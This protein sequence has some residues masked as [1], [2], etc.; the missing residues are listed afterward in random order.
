MSLINRNYFWAVGVIGSFL[1]VANGEGVPAVEQLHRLDLLPRLKQSIRV[2][3]VSSYDRTGGN[4]DG[5]SG[6]YS[7]VRKEA[8]GLVLADLKGPGVIHRIW[9]PTPTDDET[10]FYFDG[11]SSPR[12]RLKFRDLFTGTQPPFLPPLVG[13]AG[14]G[15]YSY[16]P[17]PF[18]KSV[19]VLVRA[20]KFQFYQINYSIYPDSTD[21]ATFTPDKNYLGNIERARKLYSST[22][23]DIHLY[24]TPEGASLRRHTRS[25]VLNPG[26]SLTLFET[27]QPG[28]IVGLELG[29]ASLLSGKG[30]DITLK[31]YWDGDN[32]PAV[33]APA[34]D[35]FGYAWGEPAVRSL[36]LGTAANRNYV[37][38]PMPF[39]R[40]AKIELVSET[41]A[42]APIEVQAQ[43]FTAD[44]PRSKDEG[45]F[46]AIWRR[47]NPT[48][49]GR[50]FTYI[51]TRGRGHI[52]GSILQAQGI[53]P[54]NTFFFEGDEQVTIDGELSIHGTG[55]EDSF[56][57]GWYDVP[58]RWDGRFSLPWSGCLDY[59]KPLG[60]TGGYRFLLADA[61]SFE[62]SILF[63]IEH[64]P[65]GNKMPTDYAAVTYLYSENGP[66]FDFTLPRVV[67]RRVT[68]PARVVFTPGWNVP[69][70]SFSIQN[71]SL[72]KKTVK[73]GKEEV[74]FLS[75]R[76]EKEDMFGAH[77]VSLVC[78]LPA[79][80][81]YTVRIEALQGPEQGSVQLFENDRPIGTP[82]DLYAAER[83][84]SE[85]LPLGALE[86]EEGKNVV[87]FK[88]VGRNPLAGGL[89]LDLIRVVFEKAR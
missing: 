3:F 63:T 37:Y 55:S 56:N 77:H 7:F 75:L 81:R 68:D 33:L 31:I 48:T 51:E 35:F 64:A 29:P 30:R 40:S 72:A 46:Y 82:A 71:A 53:E 5:F 6:K 69:I 13:S 54:G 80:G 21:L 2:G 28:R 86:L 23:Q 4:D 15:Y 83:K 66:T 34:G 1:A 79:A 24:S 11:E 26:Q 65:T 76:T 19:K 70:H 58:G 85:L 20:E 9:T 60:R 12:I 52:V 61:Y 78:D 84:K 36:M 45:R 38:F 17:L 50:P 16:V 88:L 89:G 32:Q 62:K 59:K 44:V 8:G 47:E 41:N 49:E 14:G 10:E 39:D 73:V 74:R 43:V 27:K 87:F 18:R 22:G 25:D 42:G 67:D 57:G